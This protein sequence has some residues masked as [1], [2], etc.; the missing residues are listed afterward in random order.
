VVLQIFAALL[1]FKYFSIC[2]TIPFTIIIGRFS[3]PNENVD[4]V[5]STEL[6]SANQREKNDPTP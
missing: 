5:L 4:V 1:F 2:S 3:K 6:V